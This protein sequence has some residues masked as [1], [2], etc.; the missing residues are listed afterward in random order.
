VI[1]T[2][3]VPVA[4]E[5]PTV[6][7]MVDEPDPGAAIEVGLKPAEAPVGSP[8]A[9][10]EIAEL[11]LPDIVVDIVEVPELPC[12]I[13]TEEGDAVMLKSALDAVTVRLTVVVCVLPPPVPVIVTVDVPVAVDVPTVIV[14]VDDPPPGAAMEVGLKAAVAPV[15]SPDADSEI[16]EL[17]LPTTAVDRVEAPEPP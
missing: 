3:D 16:A 8:D 11:K 14:I 1:V 7:V 9:E 4:V 2:V 6:I 12:L 17:K 10:S 13:D 15:G 5:A